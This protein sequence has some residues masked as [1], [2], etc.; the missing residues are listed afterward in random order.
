[1]NPS[2][3]HTLQR[4]FSE[5]IDEVYERE[6]STFDKLAEPLG[7]SLVLFGA[8]GL[9]KKALAGLRRIGIEPLAF[10]D[11]NKTLWGKEV[12]G[13]RVLSLEDAAQKFGNSAVFVVTIWK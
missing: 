8:G 2:D 12:N 3:I 4:L 5:T 9:G 6:Q 13:V 11:N 10:A 7:T 1:M